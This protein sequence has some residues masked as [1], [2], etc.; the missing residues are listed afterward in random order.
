[1]AFAA[2]AERARA[3]IA[4]PA[5]EWPIVAAEPT[6]T[7][8]L[9]RGYVVPLA[10]IGPFFGLVGAIIFEHQGILVAIVGAVLEFLLELI[11]VFVIAFVADA[12]SPAFGGTKDFVQAFKWV[13]YSSTARWA[14]GIFEVIPVFGRLI[15]LVATL[16][17]LYTLYLGTKP[18]MNI[19]HDKALGFT[20]AVIVAYIVV[21]G[22]VTWL[23]VILLALFFAGAAVA[24]GAAIR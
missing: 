14:A 24:T 4:Q 11:A 19:G 9:L 20:L 12:L 13:G 6:T 16:Y 17:S 7:T 8:A 10:I 18:A 15:F 22:I 2:F 21:I 3:M 5:Q 23:L 1:M